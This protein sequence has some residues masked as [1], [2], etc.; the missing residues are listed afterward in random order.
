MMKLKFN[1]LYAAN[2]RNNFCRFFKSPVDC[3]PASAYYNMKMAHRYPA[4]VSTRGQCNKSKE[5]NK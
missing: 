1:L 4:V 5:T 2:Y 3:L